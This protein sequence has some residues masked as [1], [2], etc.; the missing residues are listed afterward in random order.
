MRNC[1]C[2]FRVLG[3]RIKPFDTDLRLKNV[4]KIKEKLAYMV[5]CADFLHTF[6]GENQDTGT[7]LPFTMFAENI[8]KEVFL[9]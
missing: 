9:L 4:R 2:K 7:Y 1:A 8:F 6:L 5:F 3:L